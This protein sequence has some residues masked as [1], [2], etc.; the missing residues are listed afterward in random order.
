MEDFKLRIIRGILVGQP[1]DLG[2]FRSVGLIF[3]CCF[4]SLTCEL[5]GENS[6]FFVF[7]FHSN[8]RPYIR[9]RNGE[10]W[11]VNALI[12]TAIQ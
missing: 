1:S 8:A 6:F 10:I 3:Q 11:L 12:F 2:M 4:H 9:K 7:S 5:N